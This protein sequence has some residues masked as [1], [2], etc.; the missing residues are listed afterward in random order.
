MSSWLLLRGSMG[1]GFGS[2]GRGSSIR[3]FLRIMRCEFPFGSAWLLGF[4][5]GFFWAKADLRDEVRV[6]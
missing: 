3:L 6:V 1:L 4:Y 2:L 5:F